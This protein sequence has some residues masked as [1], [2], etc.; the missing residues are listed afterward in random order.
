MDITDWIY[1]LKPE[2]FEELVAE[3]LQTVGFSDVRLVGGPND[4]GI[5][6]LAKQ[7]GD[8]VAI[9][10]K[11][12]KELRP[13]EIERFIGQYLTGDNLASNILFITS[14]KIT[15][16]LTQV[17]NKVPPNLKMQLLG[18]EDLKAMIEKQRESLKKFSYP[19]QH[20]K[21][22]SRRQFAISIVGVVASIVA[23]LLPMLPLSKQKEP[24]DKQIQT[25]ESAL[26]SI[27]DL[28]S[29]LAALKD[30]MVLK[31]KATQEINEKYAKA[32]ELEKLTS[33]QLE[34]IKSTLQT[35]KWWKTL[36]QYALGFILGV[37]SS[38]VASI[39]HTQWKQKKAL[40]PD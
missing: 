5:D 28:E 11:H 14:A 12:R 18:L 39:L 30:D 37:S 40:N 26:H 15:P 38:F 16:Q 33:V 21:S 36:L 3:L 1:E 20:R 31:E 27:R 17:L 13:T 23:G 7:N 9:Q 24:L 4:K 8:S 6:I 2:E 19:A 22:V 32:K 35:E 29:H 25:V 34:V 10:V